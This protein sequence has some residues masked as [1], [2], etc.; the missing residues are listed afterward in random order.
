VPPARS[1][2]RLLLITGAFVVLAGLLFAAVL[3]LAT[4]QNTGT[5][6]KRPLF[7]GLDAQKRRD[8]RADGPQYVANPFGGAGFWLDIEDGT[9]VALVL[10]TPAPGSCSAKWKA[11]RDAYVDCHGNELTSRDLDRYVITIVPREGSLRNTVYVD[12]RKVLPAPR[13]TTTTSG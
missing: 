11:Q 6:P 5:G 4:R 13:T 1:D 2:R 12:V 7:L 3:F 8:I 10:D 9:L